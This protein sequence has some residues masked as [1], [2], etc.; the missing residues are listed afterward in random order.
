MVTVARRFGSLEA[1]LLRGRL[2][3]DGIPAVLGDAHTVQTDTLLTTALGGVRIRV[4]ASYERQALRTIADLENGAFLLD[5]GEDP[6]EEVS[7]RAASAREGRLS[8]LA[9]A[10]TAGLIVLGVLAAFGG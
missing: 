1:E 10:A 4:P 6:S 9:M 7:E 2:A 5:D 3:A 8:P